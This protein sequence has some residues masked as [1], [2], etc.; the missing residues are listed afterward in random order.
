MCARVNGHILASVSMHLCL[1]VYVYL[2]VCVSVCICVYL[3]IRACMCMWM[4]FTDILCWPTV[5]VPNSSTA[6]EST[7]ISRTSLNTDNRWH[8]LNTSPDVFREKGIAG[9]Q[10]ELACLNSGRPILLG[11]LLKGNTL[12]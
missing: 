9:I 1:C 12:F 3:F 6:G 8:T 4:S 7:T 10:E 2:C 11:Y 5:Y